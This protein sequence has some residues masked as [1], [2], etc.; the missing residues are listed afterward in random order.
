MNLSASTRETIKTVVSAIAIAVVFRSFLFEPFH[1]PSG[2]MKDTLLL[3]DYIFVA[4]Y[5]Y[6]YSRYSFP[7]GLPLFKGRV[8]ETSQ[9]E[10]GDVIVFRQPKDTS[11]DYIKRLIGLPG[12]KV[13]VKSGVLYLNGKAVPKVYAGE[14]MDGYYRDQRTPIAYHVARFKETLPNGVSYYVLDDTRTGDVDNTPEYTVPEGHYFFMGDNRDHSVDSRYM[15]AVGFVPKEN[16]IG[17]ARVVALSVKPEYSL[18]SVWNW[19]KSI[20]TERFWHSLIAEKAAEN[21]EPAHAS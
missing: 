3:G 8:F 1:I 5:E 16:I 4:K 19:G 20:R 15:D 18:L 17:H 2:S 9:P 6:G 13:Q 12:D 21:N 7:L 11:K 10:R 14:F